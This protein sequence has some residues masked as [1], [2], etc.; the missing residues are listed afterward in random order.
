MLLQPI[1]YKEIERL[2]TSIKLL[3]LDLLSL[4]W[5]ASRLGACLQ[6]QLEDVHKDDVMKLT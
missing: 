5:L 6:N 4:S 1:T 3:C 2:A